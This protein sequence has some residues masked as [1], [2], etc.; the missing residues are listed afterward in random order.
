LTEPQP[1]IAILGG[2]VAGLAAAY[3]LQQ[4]R[5]HWRITILEESD[6]LGGL[7]SAWKLGKFSADLGP[8]RIYTELPEIKA[9]LPELVDASEMITVQRRSQI[10]I[11]GHYYQYPIRPAELLRHM[12]P[13]KMAELATGVATAKAQALTG[14]H[15]AD[16]RDAMIRAFGGGVYR[17]IIGPYTEK[18]WKINPTELSPDVARVRVSAGNA[19]KLMSQWFSKDKEP[20]RPTSLKEF[21]YIRGGVQGLVETLRKKVEAAGAV[22]RTGCIVTGL[23]GEPGHVKQVITHTCTPPVEVDA[24]ISTLPLPDLTEMVTTAGLSTGDS[25]VAM[26]TADSLEYIGLVL[27]AVMVNRPQV[28]PNSWIYFPEPK[29]VFNRAYEPGNFDPS[30][31]PEGQSMLVF[32]VTARWSSDVWKKSNAQIIEEVTR[33]AIAAG[34][35]SADEINDTAA[36]RVP[37]TYPLYTRDYRVKLQRLYDYLRPVKNLVSTGRQGLFN[38]N[39]M[40]HSMLMGI[41]AAEG[42]AEKLDSAGMWYANLDQFAHFRIVD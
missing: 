31:K 21:S 16:Y 13:V 14:K 24:V 19:G 6:H 29:F 33:D 30:M 22:I 41:R 18:V 32:E 35:F 8:H 25:K 36:L 1:H 28:T 3:R 26:E 27:V 23:A 34:L 10:L 2:G 12:G 39:N 5:P 37:H 42:T 11:N 9:L 7:A 40:D 15:V 38:H 4:L 17:M 20:V